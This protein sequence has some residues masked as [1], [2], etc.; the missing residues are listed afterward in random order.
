MGS[1]HS[2]ARPVSRPAISMITGGSFGNPD[3]LPSPFRGLSLLAASRVGNR[4][5][6]CSSEKERKG[7]FLCRGEEQRNVRCKGYLYT[8]TS[9]R[10]GNTVSDLGLLTPRNDN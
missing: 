6:L 3:K 2:L 1:Q 7:L 9:E 5:G 4:L 10:L 8:S